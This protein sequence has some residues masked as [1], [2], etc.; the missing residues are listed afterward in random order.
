M[1]GLTLDHMSSPRNPHLL[2]SQAMPQAH[3]FTHSHI[4]Q[5]FHPLPEPERHSFTPKGGYLGVFGSWSDSWGRPE[6][7]PRFLPPVWW[8]GLPSW[9]WSLFGFLC[10]T[11]AH[12]L[13]LLGERL[14]PWLNMVW[15]CLAGVAFW[16]A[17]GFWASDKEVKTLPSKYRTSPH[18][19]CRR[20][21]TERGSPKLLGSKFIK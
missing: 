16:Q 9:F 8:V 10:A 19:C 4:A 1:L 17:W 15:W 11:G 14:L 21:Q 18:K 7:K 2:C 13:G 20:A 12:L 5:Y 6:F 3:S